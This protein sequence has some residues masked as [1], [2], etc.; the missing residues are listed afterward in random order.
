MCIIRPIVF[1]IYLLYTCIWLRWFVRN[2]LKR[3]MKWQVAV[4]MV[5]CSPVLSVQSWPQRLTSVI[6]V[7]C[8]DCMS[9][10][11]SRSLLR[12]IRPFMHA[13]GYAKN[14]RS[15]YLFD[16]YSTRIEFDRFKV[17]IWTLSHI[18]RFLFG[19]LLYIRILRTRKSSVPEQYIGLTQHIAMISNSHYLAVLATCMTI[20]MSQHQ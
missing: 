20:F 11:H 17:S 3:R 16:M 10:G 18:P 6:I 15:V 1:C 5:I 2:K 12:P 9:A 8:R 7:N 14:C 13:V 19:F 4:S